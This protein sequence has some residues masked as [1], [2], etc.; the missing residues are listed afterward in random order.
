MTGRPVGVVTGLAR[1]WRCFDCFPPESRP[2]WACTGVGPVAAKDGARRLLESGC[3][4][5][6]SF[7]LAGALRPGVSVGTLILAEAVMSRNGAISETDHTWRQRLQSLGCGGVGGRIAGIDAP[8]CTPVDKAALAEATQAVAADMESHAVATV[9]RAA[10]AP[11]IVVRAV[12]DDSETGVPRWLLAALDARGRPRPSAMLSGLLR[13]P[14]DL[15]A[16]LRLGRGA[17]AG[18]A[19]LRRLVVAA[20]PRLQFDS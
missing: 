3:G 1:E 8:V 10:G 19:S 14:G 17:A 12:S 20:G 4:C 11:F 9:A 5:L 18:L 6:V 16:L 13:H 2:R 7:G 15:P